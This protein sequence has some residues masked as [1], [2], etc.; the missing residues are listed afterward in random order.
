MKKIKNGMHD[1]AI[2]L[3]LTKQ[4]SPGASVHTLQPHGGATGVWKHAWNQL[5]GR[6]KY[7]NDGLAVL[8]ASRNRMW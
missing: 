6:R 2:P 7:T 5:A 4:N 3:F 8:C 1:P